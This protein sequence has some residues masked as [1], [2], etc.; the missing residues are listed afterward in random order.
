[1]YCKLI[2]SISSLD[3]IFHHISPVHVVLSAEMI[4]NAVTALHLPHKVTIA[5]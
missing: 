5:G 2:V 1:M 3:S 4:V